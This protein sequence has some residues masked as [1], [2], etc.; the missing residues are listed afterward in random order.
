MKAAIITLGLIIIA[1][2]A[3][4]A[5]WLRE[6]FGGATLLLSQRPLTVDE[7][8]QQFAFDYPDSARRVRFAS[9]SQWVAYEAI[10][11]FEAPADDCIAV[12]KRVTSAGLVKIEGPSKERAFTSPHFRSEWF[13]P[14]SIAT[15]FSGGARGHRSP[16]VWVDT[17]RGVFY[18]L[19]TD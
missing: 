13:D 4:V 9:F 14:E 2:L 1:P 7:A 3:L 17:D 19:V 6:P 15:G 10:L 18:Y 12:A 11:R 16:K 5:N 8:R